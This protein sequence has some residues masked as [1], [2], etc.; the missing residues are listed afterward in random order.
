MFYTRVSLGLAVVS[1]ARSAC[2]NCSVLVVILLGDAGKAS[3]L[4]NG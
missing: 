3:A 2:A 4:R 1:L